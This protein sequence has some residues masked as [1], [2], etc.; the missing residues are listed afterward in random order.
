MDIGSG[1]TGLICIQFACTAK[2]VKS[3]HDSITAPF[4]IGERPEK[5]MDWSKK[6][7][8][9]KDCYEMK[10]HFSKT[11]SRVRRGGQEKKV[12]A[13][14]RVPGGVNVRLCVVLPTW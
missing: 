10:G 5:L 12:C 13:D 9:V 4:E 8:A 7:N 11:A 1:S 2:I 3:I 6:L 14:Y